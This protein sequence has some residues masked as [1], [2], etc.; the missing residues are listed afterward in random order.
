MLHTFRLN[1]M[2]SEFNGVSAKE[3][4]RLYRYCTEHYQQDQYGYHEVSNLARM[5]HR[6]NLSE[7]ALNIILNQFEEEISEQSHQSGQESMRLAYCD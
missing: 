7:L 6:L 2:T 3:V 1:L 5:I 4:D